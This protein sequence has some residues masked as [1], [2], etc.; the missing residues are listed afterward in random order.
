[1]WDVRAA[2]LPQQIPRRGHGVGRRR[3]AAAAAAGSGCRGRGRDRRA[4]RPHLHGRTR[5]AARALRRAAAS[6]HRPRT[7]RSRRVGA[8]AVPRRGGAPDAGARDLPRTPARE[9]RAGRHAL[10]APARSARHGAVP[11]RRRRVRDERGR[12]STRARC[13]PGSSAPGALDVHSYHHQGVDRLGEGLVATARTRRWARA[14]IRVRGAG[15]SS[16]GCSGTP[17][18]TPRTAGCSR[19]SWPR[20]PHIASVH[21]VP[22]SVDESPST[23]GET[24]GPVS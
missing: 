21:R 15:L 9:R 13:S 7:P 4:R 3:R 16:S 5:R 11:H 10:P 1:M 23:A 20:H 19:G 12:S 17:R 18:R 22:R 8:R 24:G 6:A 2:F 14:G